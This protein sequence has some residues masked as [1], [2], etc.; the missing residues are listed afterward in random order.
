MDE[1]TKRRYF[2]DGWI[3]AYP[4]TGSVTLNLPDDVVDATVTLTPHTEGVEVSHEL[5]KPEGE[6]CRRVTLR[7]VNSNTTSVPIDYDIAPFSATTN[8]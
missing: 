2:L 3:S 8:P 5:D 1:S 6:P 4:G 7:W